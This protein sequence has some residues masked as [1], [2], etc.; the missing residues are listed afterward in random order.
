MA[1]AVRGYF[2]SNYRGIEITYVEN[3]RYAET[4]NLYSLW[5]AK[6]ELDDDILLIEGD[7]IFDGALLQELVQSQQ[8]NVAVVARYQQSMDG[9]V[10]LASN[11]LAESMVLKAKQEPGFDYGPALKTVNIY[12]LSHEGL[13]GS[14]IPEMDNYVMQNQTGQYYEAVFADLI[15]SGRLKMAVLDAGNRR[16]AEIDT[17]SDLSAAEKMFAAAPVTTI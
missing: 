14:V 12:K 5:M 17:L 6:D 8:Q 16:W 1:E 13:A 4:N 11:G 9:T 2:G 10:I 7:L 3:R 15:G